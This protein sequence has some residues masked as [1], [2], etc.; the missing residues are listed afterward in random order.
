[1]AR[2]LPPITNGMYSSVSMI[3]TMKNSAALGKVHKKALIDARVRLRSP[4]CP[5]L[6][7]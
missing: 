4:V 1:M 7:K 3:E 6:A 2:R 5:A